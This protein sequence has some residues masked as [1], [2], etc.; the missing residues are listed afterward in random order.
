M[1]DL[2]KLKEPVIVYDYEISE[3]INSMV[4]EIK[5]NNQTHGRNEP[6]LINHVKSGV[7]LEKGLAKLIGGTI[8]RQAH[9][10]RDPETFAWD[11]EA[12]GIRFEVKSSPKGDTW[13]NFN[14]RSE[15]TASCELLSRVNLSTFLNNLNTVNFLIAGFYEPYGEDGHFVKFKWL[16][17]SRTFPNYIKK[18]SARNRGTTNYYHIKQGKQNGHC[19]ELY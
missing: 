10:F 16:M 12:D 3:Q 15:E 14:L 19:V 13:F 7:I 6:T 1:L 11:V 5:E 2:D 18:S 17:G 8:N 4:Q 9:N